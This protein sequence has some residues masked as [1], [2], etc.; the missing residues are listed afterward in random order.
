[1]RRS[2]ATE[3]IELGIEG[4]QCAFEAGEVSTRSLTSEFRDETLETDDEK[5]VL[6]YPL[7]ESFVRE[8]AV[9]DGTHERM[10]GRAGPELRGV[11]GQRGCE[12]HAGQRS[13]DH[14]ISQKASS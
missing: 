9:G 6:A 7:I 3:P 14:A 12:A 8:R 11:R 1:M 2:V 4:R 10:V 5:E 13:P